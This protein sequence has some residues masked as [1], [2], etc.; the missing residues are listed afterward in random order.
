[1]LERGRGLTATVVEGV[2]VDDKASAKRSTPTSI[3]A[4]PRDHRIDN[5]KD[6]V[7]TRIAFGF[8]DPYPSS[9]LHYSLSAAAYP[10]SQAE[11]DPQIQQE[12]GI[13]ATDLVVCSGLLPP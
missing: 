1:M 10:D 13:C 2:H 5:T 6:R 11:T 9:P 3:T 7:L 8:Q 4:S 12:S